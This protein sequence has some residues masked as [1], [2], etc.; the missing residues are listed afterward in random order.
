MPA[1][2]GAATIRV[3]AGR[4]RSARRSGARGARRSRPSQPDAATARFIVDPW[5]FA[6]EAVVVGCEARRLDGPFADDAA[7]HAALAA[8][9]W[10]PLRWE[11]S[12][13]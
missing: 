8:A 1:A 10:V 9:P 13:A 5:P 6:A 2:D 11:L 7:L 4:P 3:R 12:P